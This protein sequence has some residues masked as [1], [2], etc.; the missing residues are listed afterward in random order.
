MPEFLLFC[1]VEKFLF[2][3]F[4]QLI[5]YCTKQLFDYWVLIWV[6]LLFDSTHLLLCNKHQFR[7]FLLMNMQYSH[8]SSLI[9]Q[10]F[11]Y[12]VLIRFLFFFT[13]STLMQQKCKF[14]RFLLIYIYICL[15]TVISQLQTHEYAIF[16]H[17]IPFCTTI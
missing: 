14:R 2:K 17:F 16:S 9:I 4:S 13:T 5:P 11:D 3:Y 6:F 7:R 1:W 12:R 15:L 10:L 8:I